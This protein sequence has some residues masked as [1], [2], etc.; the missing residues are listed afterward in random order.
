M[1]PKVAFYGAK[2]RTLCRFSR[3]LWG[4]PQ[5]HRRVAGEL[6]IAA[7]AQCARRAGAAAIAPVVQRAALAEIAGVGAGADQVHQRRAAQFLRQF[8]GLALELGGT[9]LVDL[10]RSGTH[11]CY[12]GERG[13]LHDWGYGCGTCPA[14]ALRARGYRQ[15]AGDA[16]AE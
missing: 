14:C 7:R 11:T 1:G 8:P 6:P 3:T 9:A 13:A 4:V 10:I 5:F 16:S 12:L 2:S 15:F